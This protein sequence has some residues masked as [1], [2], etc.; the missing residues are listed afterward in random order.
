MTNYKVIIIEDDVEQGQS[1]ERNLMKIGYSVTS[2]V[3]SGDAAIKE[4]KQMLPSVALIDT[5]LCGD[6]NAIDTARAIQENFNIP[7]VFISSDTSDELLN[8]VAEVNPYGFILKPVNE[9]ELK[10]AIKMAIDKH[11]IDFQ[12][13]AEKNLFRS[14]AEVKSVSDFIFVRSDRRLVRIKFRDLYFV[15][16]KKDYVTL[17]T[18]DNQYTTHAT[19]IEIT[20]ILPASEFKRIHRK[21]IVRLDKIITIKFPDLIVEKKMVTLPIGGLYKKDLYDSLNQI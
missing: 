13:K 15:E 17:H 6:M 20:A 11:A 10:V 14:I 9:R 1:I 7:V 16:A 4:L 18:L 3:S 21:F 8:R 2:V 12:L 19:M 5:T